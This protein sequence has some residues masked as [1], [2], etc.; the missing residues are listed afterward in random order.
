M[1]PIPNRSSRAPTLSLLARLYTA[2][3]GTPDETEGDFA[4][5]DPI[6][7][8]NRMSRSGF[9][10]RLDLAAEIG[11]QAVEITQAGQPSGAQ[12]LVNDA[13]GREALQASLQTRGLKIAALNCSGMPLHPVNGQS[14]QHLIRLTIQL[15]GQLGVKRIV[16]MS[17]SGGDGTQSTTDNWIFYPWPPDSVALRERQWEAAIELW[18]DLAAFAAEQGVEAIALELHPLHL[19][20]NVPT[21]M[22][23]RE[24]VGPIIC[25]NV[26]PSH[27][28]WQQMDPLA[29]VRALGPAVQHV[30]LK[31]MQLVK[32]QVVLAGVLDQSPFENPAQRAWIHR[33]IGHGHGADF[34]GSFIEALVD[35]DYPGAVSIENEDPYQ[36]YEAG[37]RDAA[38]FLHPLLASA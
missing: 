3:S 15:A 26:D 5:G 31:D 6:W 14:A 33:T 30:H 1:S 25:A 4:P 20:Y 24:A 28:F 11:A 34:W 38:A 17:G 27:L 37:V 8:R 9:E 13:A 19:V 29:V 36:S 18:K 2:S 32:E 35:I 21:L 22:R 23:L 10:S 12:Y 16:T 7:M